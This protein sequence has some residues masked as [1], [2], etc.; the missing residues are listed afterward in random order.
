MDDPSRTVGVV[1]NPRRKVRAGWIRDP[2]A[3]CGREVGERRSFQLRALNRECKV[4]P[5]GRAG[6]ISNQKINGL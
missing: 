2:T 1:S 4:G 6:K 5:E 3:F